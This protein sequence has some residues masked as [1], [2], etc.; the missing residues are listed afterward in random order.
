MKFKLPKL[1]NFKLKSSS[2][3]G[4]YSYNYSGYN[5]DDWESYYTSRGKKSFNKKGKSRFWPTFYRVV[6]ALA[7]FLVV[8]TLR[9]TTHPVGVRAREELKYLLTTDWNFQPALDKAVQ[10]GLQVVNMEMPFHNEFSGASPALSSKISSQYALPVSGRV[11]KK[12]GWVKDPGMGLERFNSGIYIACSPGSNVKASRSGKVARVGTDQTLGTFVLLDHGGGDFT[13]YAGL[14]NV[15]V[16]E[17]QQVEKEMIIGTVGSG[18][19]LHF[20][21]RENNELVDPLTKL[22]GLAH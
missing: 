11:L 6:V 5:P 22:Q 7:I 20:E 8:L 9:E 13:L 4:D 21:I 15:N 17:N 2:K 3:L 14:G 1:P 19:G 16:K 10:L 12:Y 18:A